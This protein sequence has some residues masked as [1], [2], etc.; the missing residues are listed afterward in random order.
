MELCVSV[1]QAATKYPRYLSAEWQ[2]K[3]WLKKKTTKASKLT[4]WRETR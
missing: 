4:V 2:I 3:T 1:P